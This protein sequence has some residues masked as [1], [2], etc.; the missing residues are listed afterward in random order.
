MN[1]VFPIIWFFLMVS[2]AVGMVRPNP[3]FS[4]GAVLQQGMSVPVWGTAADGESV[5]VE[6]QDQ[7]LTTTARD[8]CW[9]VRLASPRTGGPFTMTISGENRIEIKDIL[10]GEVWVC[11][12]QSNMEFGLA[13]DEN[14]DRV[15]SSCTDPMLRQFSVAHT[16]S[17]TPLAQVQGSWVEC[18][19]AAA[20]NFSAIGYFFG[21]DLRKSLGVPVGL[22]S[23]SY[24]GSIAQAWMS[25]SILRNHPEYGYSVADL[26]EEVRQRNRP[27]VLYNG[28]IL[29]LQPY[30]MR[31]VIWYQGEGNASHEGAMVYRTMFPDLIEHWRKDW[32]QGEFPFLFV[33][34]A[35]F[36]KISPE[37]AESGW[38]DLREA[39]LLTSQRVPATAMAVITD[40]G[41]Q[42]DIHPRKKEPVGARLALA[43]RAVAYGEKIVYQGPTYKSMTIRGSRA[44]MS[45][46]HVAGGLV[47]KSGELTGFAIAGDDGKFRNARASIV[48]NRVVVSHPEVNRPVSVRYGWANYPVVNLYNTERLPASPFRTDDMTIPALS[49]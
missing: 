4:T 19:S 40:C 11:S 13:W 25:S 15:I 43:A 48:G 18:S 23:A 37:P 32:N 20:G 47:A 38:A 41:D 30:A 46:D 16:E 49:H 5:T 34:L 14:A 1:K 36:M 7:R 9:M 21:R 10:V 33:Q 27:S 42:D 28:M 24:G 26:N 35:P 6:F 12:G 8:G 45:F 44:I 3:L 29:P 39:Q 17:E 2:P 22:I 31:G